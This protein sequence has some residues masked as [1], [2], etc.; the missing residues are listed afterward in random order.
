MISVIIPT[1]NEIDTI[2]LL[3]ADLK[4]CDAITEIIVVDGGS[5]DGTQEQVLSAGVACLSAGRGKAL[6]LNAGAAR[7][8]N[9]MLLFLHADSRVSASS[10][11]TLARAVQHHDAGCF[12]LAFNKENWLYNVYA[13]FSMFNNTLFTY[14]DQGLFVRKDIFNQVAGYSALPIME[15]IDMVQK[16]KR[17]VRFKK[18]DVPIITSARRFEKVGVIKQ[19][20]VN[21]CLVLLYSCG[22]SPKVLKKYYPY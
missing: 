18:L 11:K 13:Y 10:L 3:L 5:T 6:Q 16:L 19:Q 17:V 9:N 12:H 20:L 4:D 14:G 21:I 1:L 15:D 8:T 22:V 7:A 2:T